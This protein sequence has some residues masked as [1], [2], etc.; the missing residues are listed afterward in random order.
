MLWFSLWN[1]LNFLKATFLLYK[2]IWHMHFRSTSK[3][4]PT[5]KGTL[6]QTKANHVYPETCILYN[7][8]PQCHLF[9]SEDALLNTQDYLPNQ[10][11][12]N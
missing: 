12:V 6:A 7:L 10:T 4:P 11:C 8:I 3:C 1:G 5:A 2:V 9:S